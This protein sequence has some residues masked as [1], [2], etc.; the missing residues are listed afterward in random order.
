MRRSVLSVLVLLAAVASAR[1]QETCS[2]CTVPS[3]TGGQ[4]KPAAGNPASDELKRVDAEYDAARVR[5]DRAA[6]AA[7]LADGMIRIDADGEITARE[8]VLEKISAPD[9]SSRFS[10]VASDVAVN[11]FGDT[12]IVTSVKTDA[13]QFNGHPD[14]SKYHMTNTWV[15]KDGRWR[16]A[17]SLRTDD[18]PPYS[19]KDVSADFEFDAANVLG[20]PKAGVVIVEFSDYECSFCRHFAAETL[21]RIEK[22]YVVPGKVA[23]LYTDYPMDM[24]PRGFP[25]AIAGRCAAMGGKRWPMSVTLLRDPVALSDADFRK[26]AADARLDPAKFDRCVA[27]PA[28]AAKIRQGMDEAFRM[29]VKGTP[30]FL[31]GV[32]KP[33]DSRIHGVRLI[34]GAL[35]YDMFRATLE[36]VLRARSF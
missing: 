25:A 34:E 18:P 11:V 20:D 36:S 14:S 26:A 3:L 22:E 32:H 17:S 9:P 12:A 16:L 21:A 23:F 6:I 5:G 7:L 19:A 13:Y 1:A 2:T 27:D 29:G 31:V 24:H 28:T 15:R 4:A 35:P 30:M 10:R 33:G 8:K